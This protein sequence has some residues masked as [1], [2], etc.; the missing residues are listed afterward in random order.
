MSSRDG[1]L[2]S[3]CRE[4]LSQIPAPEARQKIAPGERSEAGVRIFDK[5]SPCGGEKAYSAMISVALSAAISE[6]QKI[7]QF[8]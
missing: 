2:V 5:K 3:F 8:T 4:T 7:R 1:T 6:G